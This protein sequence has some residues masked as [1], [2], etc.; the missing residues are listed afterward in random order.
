[1]P[2]LTGKGI[3]V[4]AYANGFVNIADTFD[5][6]GATVDMLEARKDLGPEAYAGFAQKWV[7]TG[8]TII[9]GC[10]EVGPAHIAHLAKRFG[11]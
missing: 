9:G 8:A 4:G 6:V 5:R 11:A 1:M 2:L 10:C 3:P 7:D